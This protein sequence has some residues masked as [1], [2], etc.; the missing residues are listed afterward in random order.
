MNDDFVTQYSD[1]SLSGCFQSDG[2]TPEEVVADAIKA[3]KELFGDDFEM[4][5]GSLQVVYDDDVDDNETF[6]TFY[7][8]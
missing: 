1:G 5:E 6:T 7:E 3:I 4:V 2:E 8:V